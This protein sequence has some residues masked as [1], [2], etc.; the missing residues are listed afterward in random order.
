MSST[1]ERARAYI[2]RIIAESGQGGHRATYKAAVGLMKGFG[3]PDDQ[4]LEVLREWNQTNAR[5]PWTEADLRHK[6]RDA[7]KVAGPLGYL[8]KDGR[9]T[10]PAT[11]TYFGT[12][13]DR[14]TGQ[15]TQWPRFRP[16][17]AESLEAISALR[18]LPLSALHCV[19]AAGF[20][21]GAMIDGHRA[22]IIREADFAQARRFDGHPFTLRDGTS[23][24]AKNL[25]GSEGKFIGAGWLGGPGTTGPAGPVM[26]VEGCIGLL[27][28]TAA[29]LAVDADTRGWTVLAAT[30]ASARMDAPWLERMR[31]RRVR[32]VPDNDAAG[33]EACAK[34]TVA[35]RT[36]DAVVDAEMPPDGLKDLGP[37][38]A[39]PGR[40]TSY[41][42]QLFTF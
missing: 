15:R 41:L 22:F 17:S 32:I 37:V 40:F 1:V 28:A 31:G 16:L 39:D 7:S 30:S 25:P 13:Q 3:L 5:P 20:L 36:I 10:L 18:P 11:S 19:N 23:I 4:A 38:A 27:E 29:A 9:S 8:L 34:W 33:L 2:S 24:K 21:G 14:K 35:L 6:L 12:E 42:N 26:L